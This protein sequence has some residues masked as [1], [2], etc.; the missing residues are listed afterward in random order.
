MNERLPSLDG[1]RAVA[2]TLVILQ[3]LSSGHTIP[4]LDYLWRFQFGDLGVR[5]FFVI[6]GF[7]ITS[8]LRKEYAAYGRISL[9]KFYLRRAFRIFPAYYLFLGVIAL[10]SVVGLQNLTVEEFFAPSVY[11]A[12]YLP[13]PRVLAHTW[14]LAVE[15]QFYLFWPCLI[16]LFGWRKA[17]AFAVLLCLCAPVLRTFA[18]VTAETPATLWTR[19]EYV[20]DAIA[21][22]CLYS[23]AFER[24]KTQRIAPNLAASTGALAATILLVLATA[25]RWPLFWNSIGLVLTNFL[26]VVVLHCALTA[27]D[28]AQH[29]L[30]NQKAVVWVGTISYS[31][32]LWQQ[33]FAYG[34]FK[35]DA[36]QNLVAI[37]LCAIASYY[38]VERPFIRLKS[39]VVVVGLRASV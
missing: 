20:G 38:F 26:V 19:F 2:I 15:E 4:L 30:L 29:R 32:Y 5:I 36:P 14:S 9:S 37:F 16:V 17:S 24:L 31:L 27:P 23:L 34:G 13:T 25:H 3:H 39:R 21:W 8:L 1:L 18:T 22:G 6:S 33:A 7:L 28:T 12:N 11:L 10:A 35:L